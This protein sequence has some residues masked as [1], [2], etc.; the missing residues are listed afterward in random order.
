MTSSECH[1]SAEE[2]LNGGFQQKIKE[3]VED[4]DYYFGEPSRCEEHV[5]GVDQ[6]NEQVQVK[7]VKE[8]CEDGEF[9][10]GETVSRVVHQHT[11]GF[12]AEPLKDE[13]PAAA[14][15][16]DYLCKATGLAWV[17][18][19]CCMSAG[20]STLNNYTKKVL[21]FGRKPKPDF[22]N[23]TSFY[24]PPVPPPPPCSPPPC[25]PPPPPRS[26]YFCPPSPMGFLSP[27][28]P[29]SLLHSPVSPS[30]PLSPTPSITLSISPSIPALSFSPS[31][32]PHEEYSSL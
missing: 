31:Q 11:E 25:P 9:L 18:F 5:S 12:Q 32:T 4:E 13:E 3:E 30:L 1:S 22:Y 24:Y 27:S 7:F 29:V 2:Q 6:Q 16:D 10:C 15:D 8:E 28:P 26:P 20:V 19:T 21:M 23:L 14:A 17:A